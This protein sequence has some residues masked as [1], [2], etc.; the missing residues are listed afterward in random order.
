MALIITFGDSK[1]TL[2]R[3]KRFLSQV[4]GHFGLLAASFQM[5]AM[6]TFRV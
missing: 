1:A 2:G 6:L 4:G 3:L 5:M